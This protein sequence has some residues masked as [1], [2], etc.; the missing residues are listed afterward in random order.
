M[1]VTKT[2][3]VISGVV[4]A[5]LALASGVDF[6]SHVTYPEPEETRGFGPQ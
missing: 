3:F 4:S 2:A 1:M 5:W 6:V